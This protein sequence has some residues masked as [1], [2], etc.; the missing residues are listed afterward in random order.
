MVS[1]GFWDVFI[2]SPSINISLWH[3]KSNFLV[4]NLSKLISQWWTISGVSHQ[5]PW[6]FAWWLIFYNWL[7][8]KGFQKPQKEFS[9][10]FQTW[11]P[12]FSTKSPMLPSPTY[13]C[14]LTLEGRI[15]APWNRQTELFNV[16][17]QSSCWISH[18]IK[19][20][21]KCSVKTLS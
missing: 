15:R 21:W 1:E 20:K 13:I 2:R 8:R 10:P 3:K 9:E 12:W 19:A 7:R 17:A 4:K 6:V 11:K 5:K 18:I 16:F 14:Q